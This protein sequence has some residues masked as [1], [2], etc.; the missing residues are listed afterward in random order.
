[1]IRKDRLGPEKTLMLAVLEDAVTY[2]RKPSRAR[3]VK[4]REEEEAWFLGEDSDWLFSFVSICDALGLDAKS[5]RNE[6]LVGNGSLK[7]CQ[8][9]FLCHCTDPVATLLQLP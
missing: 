7:R 5:I 4:Y 8:D 9:P 2:F 6:L 3:R 1:M